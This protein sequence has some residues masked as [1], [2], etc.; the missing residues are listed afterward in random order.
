MKNTA[1][2][3]IDVKCKL[4]FAKTT[5]PDLVDD[6]TQLTSPQLEQF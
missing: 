6:I 1:V 2:H 5:G 3:Y 4:L